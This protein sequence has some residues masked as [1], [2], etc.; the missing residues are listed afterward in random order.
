[1]TE[2]ADL[3]R[4]YP[5]AIGTDDWQVDHAVQG[6]LDDVGAELID[7]AEYHTRAEG[8]NLIQW[9]VATGLYDAATH[10]IA[11]TVIE[12]SSDAGGKV[13][14]ETVP[15]VGIVTLARDVGSPTTH[16]LGVPSF[17]VRDGATYIND[18]NQDYWI[19]DHGVWLRLGNIRDEGPPGI[20]TLPP[21]V[22]NLG[23]DMGAVVTRTRF[24]GSV[25]DDLG[26]SLTAVVSRIRLLNASM[27]FGFNQTVHVDRVRAVLVNFAMGHN[28]N[29][30]VIHVPAVIIEAAMDL[31]FTQDAAVLRERWIAAS[32]AL[33]F[34]ASA[35]VARVRDISVAFDVGSDEAAVVDRIRLLAASLAV[36]FDES[37][38]VSRIRPVTAAFDVGYG[39]A[40]AADRI[41]SISAA[42]A[43]GYDE[44]AVVAKIRP[45]AAAMAMGYA[46]AA[47]LARIRLLSSAMSYGYAQANALTHLNTQ[48]G[49]LI[50]AGVNLSTSN[51]YFKIYDGSYTTV[52][53]P[54][55]VPTGAA[56]IGCCAISNDK[57]KFAISTGADVIVI[58]L[59]SGF[60][61]IHTISGI[62]SANNGTLSWSPDDSRLLIVN[63]GVVAIY[64]TSTWTTVT[65]PSVASSAASAGDWSP[66]TGSRIAIVCSLTPFVREFDT[67]T[68]AGVTNPSSQPGSAPSNASV[69]YSPNGKFLA[70]SGSSVL[71]VY[72]RTNSMAKLTDPATLPSGGAGGRRCSINWKSDDSRV[73]IGTNAAPRLWSY[74]ISGTT[75]TKEADAATIPGGNSTGGKFTES[76]THCVALSNTAPKL[77]K[78]TVSAGSWVKDTDITTQPGTNDLVVD[79]DSSF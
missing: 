58:S 53:N 55:G 52:T 18:A 38:I 63:N 41:K 5:V 54:A 15:Q 8:R 60:S 43:L 3:C 75:I 51:A 39:Q 70:V 14:F 24:L 11:R 37:A 10:T 61:T 7:G 49:Y 33:G 6:F 62:L 69:R 76:A 20:I 44:A 26:F 34:D 73:T 68:M 40:S 42:H 67:A 29:A 21:P 79:M 4:F 27:Q 48:S 2:L 46:E 45:I 12:Y 28:V 22:T 36:G 9:E 23:F 47:A 50:T 64:N 59:A 66:G 13:D 19:R 71:F 56:T 35:T 1:M 74:T 16:G 17:L 78:Y 65:A 31:G 25:A 77:L 30:A 72:D 32:L 57:T